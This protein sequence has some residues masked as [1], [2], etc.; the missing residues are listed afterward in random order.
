MLAVT[1]ASGA[2]YAKRLLGCLAQADCDVHLV[3]SPHGRQ[4][5][6]D[7]LGITSPSPDALA[8]QFAHRVHTYR[9][10]D[11]SCRLASG[12][13]LTDG[14]V[15]CPASSNTLGAIAAGLAD[16]LITRAAHVT[17]K[18]GRRLI[19]V[20]REMPLSRI[21]L[22]NMLRISRAGGIVCPASP[23]FYMLPKAIDEL[24][25]FVVGKVMDL[26][27]VPHELNT[28]WEGQRPQTSV[29]QSSAAA[30]RAHQ[31]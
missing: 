3:I 28:R 18:E 1:G 22:E 2:V 11:L 13:F 20:P 26:L 6:A 31:S 4:L 29:P 16:N 5:L 30:P 8:G 23:G 19:V 21:E 24:V 12:S 25:D 10:H 7:E 15:V 14:M 27:A 17:L 9:Y